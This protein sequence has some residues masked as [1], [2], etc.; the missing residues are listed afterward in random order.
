MEMPEKLREVS[1]NENS[2]AT[3]R[4]S[5]DLDHELKLGRE[6]VELNSDY[7]RVL[8]DGSLIDVIKL[9]EI[10]K[11]SVEEGIGIARLVV[12]TTGGSV[13]DFAFFTK[14][15]LKQFRALTN[16]IN[17]HMVG[18]APPIVDEDEKPGKYNRSSTLRWLLDFMRPYRKKLALGI[19]FSVLLAGFNLIPPYLLQILIDSVLIANK[20]SQGLFVSLT[21]VLLASFGI[22]TVL[23]ILQSYFLNTLG[24]RVVN[25]LRGSVYEHAISLPTSFIERMTTGRILSRLTT[26]V[27]NTQWLMVWGLPTL[28]VNILTLIGIGV[29]LFFLDAGLAI[30]VL[31]PVPFIIYALIRYRK[32]SFMVYHRNWRR[33]A[34]VTAMITD[35]VPAY[36]V[37]KSF[38][39]EDREATRLDENLDKLYSAQVDA[40]KMNLYYWPALGFLTSLATIAIWW[41]GGNQVLVGKIQLG[42]VT[43]FVAYLALFYT[44]INNLSNI[45]PFIQQ[46]ITSGDR[47]REIIDAKPEVQSKPDAVKPKD[48]G[49]EILFD[50]V[51]FGYEPYNH[52]I[53]D[54]TL[55]IPRGERIAIVGRSGSGKTSIS[56][57]LM[58]FYDVDRGAITIDGIDIRDIDLD[59][60]RSKIAY[61]LQD[62]VLFDNT[63]S[64]N[65]VYGV[66]NPKQTQVGPLDVLHACKAAGIHK[67][68]M[69][70]QLAYDTNLGEKGS[71]LSGGQRQRLSLAR[72]II[73]KPDIFILDEA[74]SDLDVQSE[75][76]IYR[77]MLKLADGKTTILVTH[78]MYEALSVNNVIVMGN[79]KIVEQGKPEKLLSDGAQFASMFKEFNGEIPFKIEEDLLKTDLGDVSVKLPTVELAQIRVTQSRRISEVDLTIGGKSWPNLTPRQPFPL[80]SPQ[81]IILENPAG[82]EVLTIPDA[83][84]LEEGS[85][86][87]LKKAARANSFILK[88]NGIRK[89]VV[90]GDELDWHLTTNE[91]PVVVNTKGRRNVVVMEDKVIL[92]DP[93]DNISEIDLTK[94]DEKSLKVLNKTV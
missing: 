46:G 36:Q 77:R 45:V 24:Q 43:A 92:I 27:G 82:E 79:G 34:D 21:L 33:S 35:T 32:G 81:I 54:F 42:I 48:L 67:E 16:V 56:R 37:V 15:K 38:V 8:R 85:R 19:L 69:T 93:L 89:V 57:L 80:M 29:I 94:V 52:V 60:L 64:Y 18:S 78:N 62:V 2:S 22:I 44:P 28:T 91:G 65:V 11:A 5:T 61:V 88:V 66:S 71:S 47:L 51:W 1:S 87:T 40:V 31:V 53:K 59:Y 84:G 30:F 12:E 9:D 73:K 7:L 68:I 55:K 76:E 50:S 20:P 74:T 17:N 41:V 3:T 86:D 25:N 83:D 58:R 14:K 23:T 10:K 63:V 49:G 39:R 13:K 75:R 6:I 70:L 72:A 90:R 26:D 4:L